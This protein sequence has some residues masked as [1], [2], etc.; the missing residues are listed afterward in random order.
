MLLSYPKQL[1]IENL[2]ID[3]AQHYGWWQFSVCLFAFLALVAIWYHIGKKQGDF[4][5]VWLAISIL[6]W[7]FSGLVDIF[8][9]QKD[10]ATG[11][12]HDGLQSIFSLL[13]SLFI[14]L[15]L[16]W[17]RYL[18]KIFEGLIK[19]KFWP[20]VVGVPFLFALL[21]TFFKIV[22]GDTVPTIKELDVY[23]A[24]LTLVF[25]GAVFWE[26]FQKRRLPL[27]AWLSMATVLITLIAQIYKLLDDSANLLLFSAI[28]KT[29]LIM[30][31]FALALSWVKELIETVIPIPSALHLH[32]RGIDKTAGTSKC[33]LEVGGFPGD[34]NRE[35]MLTPALYQLLKVF[36]T[37]KL[38]TPTGWLEI[39]PKGHDTQKTYDIKDYNEVKRL[40]AAI[41]DG[42]FGKGNWSKEKHFDPLKT[43][44]FEMSEL[45]ERKIRLLIPQS[46]ITIAN[47]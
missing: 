31:F 3:V 13:N 24:L 41:C 36:A 15:A 28:F 11:I 19:S 23:Y 12:W 29:A 26:S 27:L 10:G 38:S 16:P 45:R 2:V 46:N 5:Q 33:L 18:P 17:F 22:S 47:T 7:S 6:C 40:L 35:I 14:L 4:G 37:Q 39:K 20:M 8:S 32:L 21:P 25:L 42:I 34:E 43:T 1:V 30:L 44:L 9:Y